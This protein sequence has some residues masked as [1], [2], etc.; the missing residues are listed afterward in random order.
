MSNNYVSIRESGI[1]T[2]YESPDFKSIT[3]VIAALSEA[4]R[5]PIANPCKPGAGTAHLLAHSGTQFRPITGEDWTA[6][7]EALEEQPSGDRRVELNLDADC[8][9]FTDWRSGEY[10]AITGPLCRIMNAYDSALINGRRLDGDLFTERMAT[11]CD[12]DIIRTMPTQGHRAEETSGVTEVSPG[13][14]L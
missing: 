7:V 10:A 12:V 5:L 2:Y 1:V 13:P 6:R 9:R 14:S 11:L 3:E 8:A 4:F